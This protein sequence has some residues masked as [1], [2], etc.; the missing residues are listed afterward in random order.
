MN[1]TFSFNELIELMLKHRMNFPEN[2]VFIEIK[3]A[4]NVLKETLKAFLEHEGKKSYWLKEYD[5][6][7]NWLSD[8]EGKGL[9][10]FGNCGRGKTLLG[11]YVIPAIL[12]MHEQKIVN[13]YNAQEMNTKIDEVLKKKIISIDD[14]GT[15]EILVQYGNKRLAFLEVIDAVEKEGKLIILTSNL[16]HEQI[17]EKYGER[18]MD[19]IIATTKRVVFTGKSLRIRT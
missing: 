12:L 13:C 16:N 14:I 10:M 5:E 19:R 15:E 8:N 2:R 6:V 17:I 1:T 11:R 9:F 3:D 4:K 18:T 7:A